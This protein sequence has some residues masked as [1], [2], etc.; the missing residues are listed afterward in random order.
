MNQIDRVPLDC[1]VVQLDMDGLPDLLGFHLR[2]AQTAVTRDFGASLAEIDLTQKQC[3]TLELIGAN[4]G[5][6]QVDLA[7]ILG[8]DRATMMAIVDRLEARDLVKRERSR[9]DRRRQHL[10]L[11]EAGAAMLTRAKALIA[12]HEERFKRR[13]SASELGA[14]VSSLRRIHQQF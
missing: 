3:A 13:F 5:V 11:T 14:L 9:A 7:G 4:P 10:N 2:L 12:E 1:E 6:S 8:A